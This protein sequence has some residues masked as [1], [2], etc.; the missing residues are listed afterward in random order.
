MVTIPL[1][2]IPHIVG[3]NEVL[4][5]NIELV[6]LLVNFSIKNVGCSKILQVP[7]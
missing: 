1:F 3:E 6:V 4:V 5:C 7:N 2:W